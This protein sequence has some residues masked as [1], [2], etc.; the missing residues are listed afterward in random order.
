[1]ALN[2]T[3]GSWNLKGGTLKNGTLSESGGA[4]LV[5]TTSGGTFDAATIDGDLDLSQPAGVNL[6]VK[7][8]LVL[9]GTMFLGKSD[10][11]TYGYVY[12]GDGSAGAQTLSGNAIVLMG[13]NSNN[14]LYNYNNGS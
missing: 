12:F 8:S 3:T 14:A 13:G 4:L 1:M 7:N 2:A 5:G 9:N 11:S 6:T 10:S